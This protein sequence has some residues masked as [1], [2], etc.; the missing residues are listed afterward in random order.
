VL[1]AQ[2]GDHLLCMD[3]A[4]ET[5]VMIKHRKRAQVVFVEEFS[6]FFP[7]GINVATDKVAMWKISERN[8]ARS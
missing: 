2:K 7:I 4:N 1:F 8:L 5:L 6:H 3:D